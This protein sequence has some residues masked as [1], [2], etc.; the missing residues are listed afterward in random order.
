MKPMNLSPLHFHRFCQIVTDYLALGHFCIYQK[1]L[2]QIETK[3][4]DSHKKSTPVYV[5]LVNKTQIILD[6]IESL[7]HN[8]KEVLRR[9]LSE[10]GEVISELLELEDHLF[11]LH[12][13]S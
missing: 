8:P 4:T 1:H 2:E 7:R 5:E 9:E 12:Q 10:L 3:H 13:P 11:C 6:M